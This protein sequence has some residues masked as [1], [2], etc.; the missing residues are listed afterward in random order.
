MFVVDQF[1]NVFGK[2]KRTLSIGVEI[3]C[4]FI[5]NSPI[6]IQKESIFFPHCLSPALGATVTVT[7]LAAKTFGSILYARHDKNV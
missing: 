2:R 1:D 6:K 4:S 7:Q 5:S 3:K